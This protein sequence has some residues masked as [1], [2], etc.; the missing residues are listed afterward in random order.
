MVGSQ[1]YSRMRMLDL[2]LPSDLCA[3]IDA[4]KEACTFPESRCYD[5]ILFVIFAAE[6]GKELA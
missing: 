4:A 6:K 2:D 3:R 1:P 5:D